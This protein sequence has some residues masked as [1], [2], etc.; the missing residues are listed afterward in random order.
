MRF[1]ETEEKAEQVA[2]MM[3]D[4]DPMEDDGWE[5]NVAEYE[6]GYVVEV[7]DEGHKLGVI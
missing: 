2:Q 7:W 5:Y 6:R 3:R 1:Y 4:N